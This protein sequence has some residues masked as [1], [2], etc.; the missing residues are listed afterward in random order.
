VKNCL[1]YFAKLN[2]A[3]PESASPPRAGLEFG[4]SRPTR[5][6]DMRI[7][8]A[9]VAAFFP[10][11][12]AVAILDGRADSQCRRSAPTRWKPAYPIS[13]RYITAIALGK[14]FSHSKP[15]ATKT[16]AKLQPEK[17]K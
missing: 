2:P 4:Q 12:L 7:R 17:P 15:A 14:V 10:M 13:H 8:F 5:L 11:L 6:T 1:D 9:V 16:E 3:L